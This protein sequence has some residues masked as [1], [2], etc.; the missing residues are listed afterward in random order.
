MNRKYAGLR[1]R[2]IANSV[3]APEGM[4]NV[5]NGSLC[6]IWTGATKLN[7][8]GEHYPMM[9]IRMKRGKRKGKPV[10]MGAHRVSLVEFKGRIMSGRKKGMHLCNVTLCV[11]PDHLEGGSQRKNV[12]QCVAEGRHW[13]GFRGPKSPHGNHWPL[14]IA[15]DILSESRITE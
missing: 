5:C 7:N 3:I 2:I 13:S 10:P 14:G 15:E 9:T 11:N 12:R 1:E 6:W 8:R 4:G